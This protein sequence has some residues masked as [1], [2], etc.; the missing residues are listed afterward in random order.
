[1]ADA[2]SLRS[3]L[4]RVDATAPAIQSS[5]AQM[6]K[7][8]DRSPGVAVVEWRNALHNAR[9]DQW[10]PLLYVANE[11]LQ[12]SKRNRGN[13]FLEAFSPILGQSLIFVS[14][15]SDAPAVEKIRRTV[16]IWG[17]RRVFSVRYVNEL[18][19]GLEPYRNNRGASSAPIV[20]PTNSQPSAFQQQTTA[21]FNGM[22]RR[23]SS[24]ASGG[25]QS[26]HNKRSRR[27]SV[28]STTSLVELWKG[29]AD[30]D[31][32]FDRSTSI[33]KDI[34]LP[35][36]HHI[37]SLVGDELLDT[38]KLILKYQQKVSQQREA[39]YR[40][41]TER[42]NLEQ[43]A[44]RYIPWLEAA[45]KQDAEDLKFCDTLE[46]AIHKL[47]HVHPAIRQARDKR[48]AEDL[49]FQREQE[50]KERKRKEEEDAKQFRE[51]ALSK[52]TEAKPGMVWNKVTQE[53]QYVNTEESWRD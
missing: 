42:R 49:R 15:H 38:H 6:M 21:K 40:I 14:Q 33:L 30:L 46:T 52:E 37:E 32:T 48:V 29:V 7:H 34:S 39:L 47:H 31:T 4:A 10:L 5:A 45:L 19:K 20:Q 3:N 11:V 24:T 16:K 41:A 27:R 28:L 9:R 51:A 26:S 36:T 12:N 18:L 43:D 50:E 44:V 8:Y 22:K 25:S 1:M 23:R 2:G 53:Y 35:E 13:K 17:D